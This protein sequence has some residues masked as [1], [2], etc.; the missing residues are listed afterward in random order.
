MPLC[1]AGC[2]RGRREPAKARVRPGGV[3]VDPPG[4]DD[5]DGLLQGGEQGLIEA[6]VAQPAV[7]RFDEAVLRRFAGC[8]V[9]P[10]DA[11]LLLPAEHG[12]RSELAAIGA[13]DHAGIAPESGNAV[14]LAGDPQIR[15]R[16]VRERSQAF[17]AEVIDHDQD[18]EASAVNQCVGDEV[19]RP[20]LVHSAG[21]RSLGR[22]RRR[23]KTKT[24][25]CCHGAS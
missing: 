8:D 12:V 15:E 4:F 18:A 20:A 25:I 14:Q 3:V 17:A 21:Y 23:D 13:D 16:G 6:F 9:V 2:K 1:G 5:L 11:V 7:E 19:E 10:F 24:Q 22:E